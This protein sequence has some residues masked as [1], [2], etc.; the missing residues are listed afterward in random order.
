[1]D[2]RSSVTYGRGEP[3]VDDEASSTEE[4][5]ARS[6]VRTTPS[7]TGCLVG[8]AVDGSRDWTT[9]RSINRVGIVLHASHSNRRQ[10]Q[11]PREVWRIYGR[12][13]A[14]QLGEKGA[15]PGAQIS[16]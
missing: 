9:Y 7:L 16:T 5:C 6:A 2:T 4:Y 15:F 13:A 3:R 14:P 11:R 1:M 10:R 12:A 8:G